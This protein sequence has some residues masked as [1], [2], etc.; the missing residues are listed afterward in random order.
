MSSEAN[1]PIP[2]LITANFDQRLLDSLRD[3]SDRIEIMH[4]PTDTAS[5]VPDDVWAQT[6]VLYTLRTLPDPALVPHLRWIQ[7][8]S[9][10]V[11]HLLD[12][13][14]CQLEEVVVTTTSGIHA[15]NMTEYVFM[16]ML[17]FGHRLPEMLT[18][19]AAANWPADNRFATFIPLELRGSTVGIVG[20]G[21]IGREIAHV[22]HTFGM[23]V[24][25][26]KRDVRHPADEDGY[27][28]PGTGDPEGMYFHRLY[29]P[30]ALVSMVKE[31]DFVV[32]TVPLTDSTR[33]MV[34]AAVLTSMKPT[35]YLINVSRGGV[36]DEEALLAALQTKQ[37]AGAALDVFESEPLPEDSPLWKLPN[38]IIS[39]HIAGNTRDYNEKAARLF[40][41][42]LER[43]LA[44][45]DLLNQVDRVRGY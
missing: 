10:G 1:T 3:I 32:V 6:E 30:E 40:A 17:A 2:V 18:H 12:R 29:P 4:Y 34:G 13:K 22:A 8:H 44:R 35:A 33:G 24:L 5:E 39:P 36:V 37:I 38:L 41:E 11:D 26:V 23:Q 27:A 21:S 43:Y 20:Y 25:A 19:Q 28:V 31:S 9:A 7:T 42:N 14:I 16:M 45:K 15:T